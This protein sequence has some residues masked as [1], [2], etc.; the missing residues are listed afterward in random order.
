MAE[1][2][3]NTEIVSTN[4]LSAIKAIDSHQSVISIGLVS[5]FKSS[6]KVLLTI[7]LLL[8]LGG[9]TAA[10]FVLVYNATKK[11]REPSAASI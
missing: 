5:V 3:L 8:V 9:I 2:L 4:I 11:R 10:F 6:P 7:A 1:A